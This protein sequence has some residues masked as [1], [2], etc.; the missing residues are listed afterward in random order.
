M[1]ATLQEFYRQREKSVV[2]K[3]ASMRRYRRLVRH[4]EE[5]LLRPLELP[6]PQRYLLI[7]SVVNQTK[8]HTDVT[9]P[10]R[11]PSQSTAIPSAVDRCEIVH[12]EGQR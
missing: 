2:P 6:R 12:S 9:D 1:T 11:F 4:P 10:F 7:K 8:R 5:R 3:S